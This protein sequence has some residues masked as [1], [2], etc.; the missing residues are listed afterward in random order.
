MGS[1][2]AKTTHFQSSNFRLLF[3]PPRFEYTDKCFIGCHLSSD[4]PEKPEI[5]LD[6]FH[7]HFKY[8]NAE[9][10]LPKLKI[11]V[12]ARKYIFSGPSSLAVIPELIHYLPRSPLP[13]ATTPY[14]MDSGERT[15]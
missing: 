14:N 8:Y 9:Q 13:T 4:F 15:S 3:S 11:R 12:L 6:H 7:V 2:R 1:S 5:L 10:D